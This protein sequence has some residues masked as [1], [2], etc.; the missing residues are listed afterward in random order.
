MTDNV[1]PKLTIPIKLALS[2]GWPTENIVFIS[3]EFFLLF[4]YTQIFGLSGTLTGAALFLAMCIDGISDPILG[5]I[6]DNLRNAR[7]GRRHSLMFLA[8][9]PLAIFFALVF[10]PPSALHGLGLF[11]WLAL[12][13]IGCRISSGL[14]I[15]PF[16]T[17]IAE[18]TR[19]TSE[20][21]SISLYTSVVQTLFQLAML[22]SIK[23]FFAPSPRFP[24]GQANP[25]HYMPYALFWAVMLFL[26][27]SLSSAGTYRYMRRIEAIT[28]AG[29][30]TPQSLARFLGAWKKALLGNPNVRVIFLGSI[31]GL[32]ASAMGRSLTLHMGTY[33]WRLTTDQIKN[34]QLMVIPGTFAG[35]FLARFLARRADM[36][37]MILIGMGAVYL[38]FVILPMLRLMGLLPPNGDPLLY[39]MLLGVNVLQGAGFGSMIVLSG[40]MCAQTA[41]EEEMLLGA[42]EQG[43]LYGFIFLATKL[44]SG[45][46]K[47]FSGVSLDVIKFPIGRPPA[48]IDPVV[49]NH[50]ALALVVNII[51][52]GFGSLF[53]WGRFSIT[54]TRHAEITDA[55]ARRAAERLAQSGATAV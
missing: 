33:F 49:T 34:W 4:Y 45:L 9:V 25:A 51:L 54:R 7:W 1:R 48:L 2:L 26:V 35:L 32:T 14:F 18:M 39:D 43:L 3:F 30:K 24:N 44:G 29:P 19:Q 38:S 13:A 16:A 40:L 12:T 46:G 11:A 36:K 5:T 17:Q 31:A 37:P 23:Y 47:L 10:M 52:F 8:P 28:P 41:D 42:P 27:T 55:L 21:A 6:S 50:L 22:Q 15:I 20:R 53:I